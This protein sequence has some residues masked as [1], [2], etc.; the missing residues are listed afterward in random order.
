LRNL[1]VLHFFTTA[2]KR[3]ATWKDR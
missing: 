1:T 2:W 3:A